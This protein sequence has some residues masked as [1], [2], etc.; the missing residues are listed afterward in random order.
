M[1]R[2]EICKTRVR[3]LNTAEKKRILCRLFPNGYITRK[4][5]E[6]NELTLAGYTEEGK[7]LE[8]NFSLFDSRIEIDYQYPRYGKDKWECIDNLINKAFGKHNKHNNRQR[9]FD[10][11]SYSY[12]FV[13]E[14]NDHRILI[15]I[16]NNNYQLNNI[17][18]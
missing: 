12:Y 14:I 15:C 5:D 6:D 18:V 2:D 3:T 7:L 8:V 13:M 4:D 17:A 10:Y 11:D 16:N 9:K 1:T